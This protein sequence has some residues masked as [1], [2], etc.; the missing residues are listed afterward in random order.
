MSREHIEALLESEAE[1]R[2]ILNQK[3]DG[4]TVYKVYREINN[5]LGMRYS[6]QWNE[7][8]SDQQIVWIE[9]AT[10]VIIK[11]FKV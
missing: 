3:L 6:K 7:L 2:A 4:E 9:F 8:T 1:K 5:R 11:N 10:K